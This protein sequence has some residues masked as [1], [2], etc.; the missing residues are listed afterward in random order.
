MT[1]S[2]PAGVPDAAT[3]ADIPPV[4]RIICQGRAVKSGLG[5]A[6]AAAL[7]AGAIVPADLGAAPDRSGPAADA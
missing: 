4:P 7:A 5:Y 6:V 1:D 2:R 3:D